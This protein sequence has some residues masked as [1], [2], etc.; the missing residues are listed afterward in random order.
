LLLFELRP[1]RYAANRQQEP[2]NATGGY[3]CYGG[4]P[5]MCTSGGDT[6]AWQATLPEK[7]TGEVFSELREGRR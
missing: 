7:P 4:D 1:C 3:W 5:A 6:R 2:G